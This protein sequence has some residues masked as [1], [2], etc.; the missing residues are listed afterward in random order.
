[1]V[2]I[3]RQLSVS[4]TA[5]SLLRGYFQRMKPTVL[6]DFPLFYGLAKQ[7][8]EQWPQLSLQSVPLP[9]PALPWCSWL[10]RMDQT[11]VTQCLL[12]SRAMKQSHSHAVCSCACRP[13]LYLFQQAVR[14][15]REPTGPIGCYKTYYMQPRALIPLGE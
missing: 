15:Y 8:G 11:L 6:V 12:P 14:C 2:S 13:D 4:S 5:L 7:G 3:R 9:C 1:M 10:F